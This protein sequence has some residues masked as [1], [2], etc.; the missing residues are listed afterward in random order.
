MRAVNNKIMKIIF[1]LLILSLFLFFNTELYSQV[2]VISGYVTDSKTGEKLI[3]VNIINL[4][5]RTGCVSNNFGYYS[6]TVPCK[7]DINLQ[8]SYIGYAKKEIKIKA[9][10]VLNLDIS[11]SA[12]DKN[13][14]DVNVIANR[15]ENNHQVGLIN[16]PMK[17]I[18]VLPAIFGEKDVLRAY[19]LMPGVQGGKE[20]S[21]E[22][23]IR[24]GSPDQ[25]LILVDD[26]PL[27]YINHIGGFVSVFDDNAIKKIDL[28]KGGFP[29]QYGGCLSAITDI[30]MKDGNL[31]K[32]H[33]T[34]SLGIISTKLMLEGPLK[35]EKISYLISARRSIFDIFMRP[36]SLIASNGE[37]QS[38]YTFFDVNFK[39][40]NIINKKN[41]LFFSFYTGR[42]QLFMNFFDK[43]SEKKYVGNNKIFWGN[44]LSA[45][46]WNHIFS[47]KIFANTILSYTKFSYNTD[48]I[49]TSKYLSGKKDSKFVNQYLS[50]ISDFI[51]K[52]NF[53]YFLNNH[54]HF[55]FGFGVSYHTYT[56]GI[57][58][59][60]KLYGEI[61]NIDTTI[62]SQLINAFESSIYI[63]DEI[64]L[65]HKLTINIGLRYT[66]FTVD[67]EIFQTF[68]PRFIADYR[69]NT[70]IAVKASY[71][72]MT[73][74]IHLLTNSSASQPTD[75]W[76]PATPKLK[77]EN[78]EQYSL[79]VS[80]LLKRNIEFSIEGF[81]KTMDHLI[82]YKEG[83][84]FFS[85]SKDWQDKVETGGIG[86]VSGIE[87]LLKKNSG[88]L[89]G[90]IAY[91]WSKNTRQFD[92]LNYGKPYPYKYDRTHDLS[93]VLIYQ[94]KK[95]ITLSANWIF[96]NGYY[97]TLAEG[98]YN[99]VQEGNIGTINIPENSPIPKIYNYNYGYFSEYKPAYI[100]NG[101]NNYQTNN[102]HRLDL[103]VTYTKQ[104]KKGIRALSFSIYNVYNHLNPYYVY[105][106]YNKKQL[107]LYQYSLFTIMPSFSYS[108]KF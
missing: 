20:G 16:I 108:F 64:S 87:M 60:K 82:D 101:K 15:F 44:I 98:K 39:L 42:D 105:Y 22:L 107:S 77:P 48:F 75:L 66:N 10:K 33:G 11:L 72:Q 58:S 3:G 2:C 53:D 52:S 86:Q 12:K 40:Q 41:R 95:N 54:H 96:T 47:P 93:I 85:N 83:A 31:H 25:N 94:L 28:I 46:R 43:D 100:Y 21:S 84:S 49:Y 97:L 63:E 92:N 5:S 6:L 1:K 14:E 106:K 13:I 23:Y 79:G 56:P 57:A 76:V 78:S 19:M 29:A 32:T 30:R 4:N 70:S 24:G 80:S 17:D 38:A 55:K 90:W 7:T 26:V 103:S 59:F 74:N 50:D 61:Q 18:K 37:I 65:A 69:I 102:Y 34:F 62:G 36:I 81:Y 67:G 8:F 99:Q 91:T 35:R 71:A 9:Q 51:F 68:Q 45:L 73:Q 89:K 88:L 27:Y 104:K